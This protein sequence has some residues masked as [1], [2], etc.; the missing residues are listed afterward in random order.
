MTTDALLGCFAKID[1]ASELI[2]TLSEKMASSF[3]D[4]WGADPVQSEDR[5]STDLRIK[6]PPDLQ[7]FY[8]VVVGEILH[9]LRSP[10]DHL[11]THLVEINGGS[12]TSTHNFPVAN[13]GSDF[14]NKIGT[15]LNG[16]HEDAIEKI[17]GIQPFDAEGE[18]PKH[19]LRVLTYLSNQDKHRVVHL[20]VLG[21]VE[22]RVMLTGIGDEPI[23]LSV[24]PGESAI[25]RIPSPDMERILDHDDILKAPV[26]PTPDSRIKHDIKVNVSVNTTRDG[27]NK[28]VTTVLRQLTDFVHET[29]ELLR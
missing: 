5:T 9:N 10:L 11:V 15:M 22:S 26:P 24:A 19:P 21:V 28:P 20:M 23:R 13:G 8:G 12:S 6:F 3:G 29:V 17:R 27:D 25:L 1:R 7:R 14:D 16:V 18:L 4:E 2:D